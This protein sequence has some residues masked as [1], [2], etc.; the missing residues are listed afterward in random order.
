M[1]S[2]LGNVTVK[3]NLRWI[4]QTIITTTKRKFQNNYHHQVSLAST[5]NHRLLYHL[6]GAF[7]KKSI[8]YTT[9]SP[10]SFLIF[11]LMVRC[12]MP[13]SRA[14]TWLDQQKLTTLK[15]HVFPLFSTSF[16]TTLRLSFEELQRIWA[17]ITCNKS[18][19]Q[20]WFNYRSLRNA[21]KLVNIQNAKTLNGK[22][23]MQKIL[24]LAIK[25]TLPILKI[26]NSDFLYS[27]L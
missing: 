22:P 24:M 1:W 6:S 7:E 3:K 17:P 5:T 20:E 23:L 26:K 4:S 18:N 9:L 8:R 2:L 11:H 27:F 19:G 25:I 15:K 10:S 12:Q 21:N 16:F 13:T 14:L